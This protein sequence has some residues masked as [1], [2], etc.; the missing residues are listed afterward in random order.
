M[1]FIF[2]LT[3]AILFF[4]SPYDS[5]SSLEPTQTRQTK[6]METGTQENKLNFSYLEKIW[7]VSPSFAD[8]IHTFDS[9]LV[10]TNET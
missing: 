3:Q 4:Y 10:F 1:V 5:Y 6:E 7:K 9:V 8:V 2:L